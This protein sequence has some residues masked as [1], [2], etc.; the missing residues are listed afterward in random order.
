MAFETECPSSSKRVHFDDSLNS[1]VIIPHRFDGC[2]C[3]SAEEVHTNYWTCEQWLG[4]CHKIYL[5]TFSLEDLTR[6]K[7]LIFSTYCN[8]R[9]V[10]PYSYLNG[11]NELYHREGDRW[12][13]LEP[14]LSLY[15]SQSEGQLLDLTNATKE[16]MS[17]TDSGAAVDSSG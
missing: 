10:L 1:T 15:C 8:L 7:A 4:K 9:N 13:I 3:L 17:V 11:Q 12:E 5:E 2:D 16:Y 6:L 14:S